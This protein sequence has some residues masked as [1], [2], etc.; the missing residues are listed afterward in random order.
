MYAQTEIEYSEES[1]NNSL[2]FELLNW[3][4]ALEECIE[5]KE[6]EGFKQRMGIL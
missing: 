6:Q 5:E 1:R 4:S 3:A 2:Y